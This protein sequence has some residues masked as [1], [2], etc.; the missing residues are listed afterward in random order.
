MIYY[1][2]L[3]FATMLYALSFLFNKKV[4]RDSE[5]GADGTVLFLTLTWAE[6]FVVLFV[7]IK[8]A[9]LQNQK[10][11]AAMLHSRSHGSPLFFV[12][13]H[14]HSRRI[15]KWELHPFAFPQASPCIIKPWMKPVTSE[16][17]TSPPMTR[18]L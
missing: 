3:I 16:E 4:E 8:G 5:E 10:T 17:H 1:I 11:G 6:I 14:R 7:L 12:V 2:L 13:L 18:F 9:L 15:C